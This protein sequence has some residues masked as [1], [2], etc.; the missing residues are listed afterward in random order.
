M[1]ITPTFTAKFDTNFGV[2]ATAARAA[3]IAASQIFV[4]AFSD[5]IHINITVD[6]LPGTTAFG[7]SFPNFLSIAYADLFAAV[8][9]FASTANDVI[10]TGP[11]GSMTPTDPTNGAGSWL[12]ARPQAKAL[13]VIPDDLSDD[14]G[15]TFG[16]GNPF[17]FSGAIAAGTFDFQA[18]AAH[19]IAEV[20]GRIGLSGG[21]NSFSLIDNF[22]YTG[23][24]T[25][26]LR[27]G[28]G[29]FFSINNGVTLLKQYND[30]TV[31]HLDTRDWLG[32][33]PDAFNQFA[34]G[35][36]K[37]P[38]SAVDLQVMDVIGYGTVKP[39]GSLIETI[40]HI[41]FL[42]AH[43]LGSGFGKAPNFL[44]C[45]VIVQLA[46]DPA[47]SFGL[48]LRTDQNQAAHTQMFD[49]LRSAFVAQRP[50]RLDYITIGPRVGEIIRVANA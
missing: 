28:P 36:V 41:T 17:T 45:E 26:G 31:N 25:K 34:S 7:R 13:H 49:L 4:H 2:N 44:D 48:K 24:G 1:I 37:N 21:N 9:A 47:R 32:G 15:T 43:E 30:P 12:L 42:R 23:A 6:A 18:V 29:N 10:A 38:V 16:A 11:G 40:G 14:G 5:D 20:M 19:E 27:G 8:G 35:G 22:S 39:I 46:E 3:W 50:V 33:P